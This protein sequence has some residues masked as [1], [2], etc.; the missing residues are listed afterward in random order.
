MVGDGAF[1]PFFLGN[2]FLAAFGDLGASSDEGGMF[3]SISNMYTFE[4]K[5]KILVE[6]LFCYIFS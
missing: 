1:L 5:K 4:K 3:K 2:R 6:A